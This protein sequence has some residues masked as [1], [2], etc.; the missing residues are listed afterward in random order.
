MNTELFIARRLF[1]E[2][3]QNHPLSMKIIHVALAGIALGISLMLIA[4][5]VVTGFKKEIGDKVAGFGSHVQL[6]NYDSNISYETAPVS[7]EQNFLPLLRQLPNI[8]AVYPFATKPGIIKTEDFIQGVVLKGVDPTYDWSF[9]AKHLVDGNIPRYGIERSPE[10][11]IS[12]NL[13]TLLSLKINDPLYMFFMNEN[14]S[15]PRIRQLK[16]CGIFNTHLLEF[17]ELFVFGDVRQIQ[18][19]NNWDSLQVSGF[20]IKLHDFGE[21]DE[22]VSRIRNC[23][24]GYSSEPGKTLRMVTVREKYPQIFDW[25]SILD[26]NVWVI[27]VLMVMVAGFNMISALLVLILE[28]SRMIGTLKALGST[29]ASIGRIFIYL[30]G[31]LISRGLLWGNILGISFLLAQK[32]LGIFRLDPASYF[33]EIV[34]VRLSGVAFIL[35]NAGALVTTL[36]MLVLPAMFVSRI[37]PEKTLR[38]D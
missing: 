15:T 8:E 32:Y 36:M 24:T 5:A 34:P 38:F 20:E 37:P 26:M 28:R 19:I 4:V 33:M 1:R 13:S 7:R 25:L 14:E 3:E 2:K 18:H 21:L 29:S 35:L 17:D 12:K 23:V 27:L 11:L 31:F 30:S 6:V 10:V 22:S 16:I 9:F